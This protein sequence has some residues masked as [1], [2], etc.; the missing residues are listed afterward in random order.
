MAAMQPP[1]RADVVFGN[2]ETFHVSG[3]VARLILWLCRNAPRIASPPKGEV[4]F[5]FRAE[6]ASCRLAEMW[7]SLDM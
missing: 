5:S 1:L 4:V 3:R 7:D 2:G 6:Q